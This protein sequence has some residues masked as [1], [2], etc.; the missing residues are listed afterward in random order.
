MNNELMRDVSFIRCS[1]MIAELLMKYKSMETEEDQ[2]GLDARRGISPL[3]T[4]AIE[5]FFVIVY[6]V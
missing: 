5:K 1:T 6:T 2:E 4:A 3:L